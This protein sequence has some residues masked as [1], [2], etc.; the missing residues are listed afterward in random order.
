[1]KPLWPLCLALAAAPV[2]AAPQDAQMTRLAQDSGCALC[3]A[4]RPEPRGVDSLLPSAP[5][6]SDIAARYR[7]QKGVA[8]KLVAEVINGIGPENR[9][10]EYKTDLALMPENRVTISKKDATALIRWI[11]RQDAPAPR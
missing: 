10:W 4:A 2:L 6:W 9:H 8:D 1:M 5:A 7:G 3:H 11:L